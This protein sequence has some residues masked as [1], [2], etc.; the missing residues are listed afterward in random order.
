MCEWSRLFNQLWLYFIKIIISWWHEKWSL[1]VTSVYQVL[2]C[3]IFLCKDYFCFTSRSPPIFA[4]PIFL[5]TKCA[6]F[7]LITRTVARILEMQR[8]MSHNFETNWLSSDHNLASGGNQQ[9]MFLE[10]K[11]Q[12][13]DIWLSDDRY[14]GRDFLFLSHIIV[15]S[16][17]TH[18]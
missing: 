14:L 16:L 5:H 2:L 4:I 9:P 1:L 17:V 8:W 3:P 11:V 18:R 15:C 13:V 7:K 6:T 12:P 10:L